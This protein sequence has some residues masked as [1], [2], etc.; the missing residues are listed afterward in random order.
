MS[1]TD[2][3]LVT[4]SSPVAPCPTARRGLSLF[5]RLS[6]RKTLPQ[7]HTASF[8]TQ[9]ALPHDFSAPQD[10]ENGPRS[11]RRRSEHH[12]LS[13]ISNAKASVPQDVRPSLS[14]ALPERPR[15]G[16]PRMELIPPPELARHAGPA[17][18]A[19]W[20][21]EE[22]QRR[23]SSL[24]S[25]D[26]EKQSDFSCT[27]SNDVRSSTPTMPVRMS[28]HGGPFAACRSTP[29]QRTTRSFPTRTS[30]L[31]PERL[32]Y[33]TVTSISAGRTSL[34]PVTDLDGIAVDSWLFK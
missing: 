17:T 30:N 5:R 25:H 8:E 9:E 15:F 29:S 34:S 12:S 32:G 23:F 13:T 31:G 11:K 28:S 26:E 10:N 21:R 24:S 2:N 22:I 3:L 33:H 7:K 18:L 14:M 16:A 1:T 6:P 4:L 19:A 27:K 20:E